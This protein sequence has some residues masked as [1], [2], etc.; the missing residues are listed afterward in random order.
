MNRPVLSKKLNESLFR[1][2]YYLK[3]ELV[4]F[5]KLEGI[6][7]TGSKEELTNRIAHFLKTGDKLKASRKQII[8]NDTSLL[9]LESKIE[10]NFVCSEIHRS[11]FKENIGKS[12]SFNV[13]FQQWLKKNSGKTYKEAIDAY[14]QILEDKKE[15][16]TLIA[17][18]FEYN[19]YIRD[20]FADNNAASLN[21]AIKCW[22]YKKSLAGTNKYEKEDLQIL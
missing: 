19:T 11:F 9:S 13:K 22:T 2:F 4:T 18:Q 21:D 3:E 5:C 17:K 7:A 14:Y 12:F 15:N 16:K 6:Q 20:F 10:E 8:K 1:D